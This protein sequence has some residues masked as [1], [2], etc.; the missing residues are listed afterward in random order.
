MEIYLRR[1]G[2]ALHPDGQEALEEISKLPFGKPLRAEVKRDRSGPHHRLFWA[3]C[4]RIGNAVG[5]DS[6]AVANVLKVSTGHCTW[7]Q[8][9]SHGRIPLP[10]SISFREMDQIA[11]RDFFDKCL[12]T[13]YAEWGVE[14][15][16][17]LAA[18]EDLVMPTE[19]RG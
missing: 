15:T 6:E 9:K 4:S 2:I 5:S 16:D 11:F 10:K 17:I 14:R 19:V 3:L 13:I 8:T 12:D 18:I 1:V 7:V